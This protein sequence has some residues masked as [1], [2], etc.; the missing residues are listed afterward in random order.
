MNCNITSIKTLKEKNFLQFS[1]YEILLINGVIKKGYLKKDKKNKL[2]I[3]LD[4]CI[5]C[6]IPCLKYDV[7]HDNNTSY[8][9]V[10]EEDIENYSI[11]C[12]KISKEEIKKLEV[13][14]VVIFLFFFVLVNIKN[15]IINLTFFTFPSK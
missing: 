3:L 9:F 10:L 14:K 2:K 13:Q 11:F 1:L 4:F 15:N 6:N 7:L 5:L 8:I 12:N